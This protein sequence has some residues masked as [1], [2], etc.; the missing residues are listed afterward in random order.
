MSLLYGGKMCTFTG[1][2]QSP[3]VNCA[4]NRDWGLFPWLPDG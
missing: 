3:S 2:C 4:A 1:D